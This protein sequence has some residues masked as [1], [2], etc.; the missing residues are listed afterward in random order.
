MGNVTCTSR[1]ADLSRILYETARK[2]CA[3]YGVPKI[4]FARVLGRR[5]H[6]LAGFGEETY[7]PPDRE[8][9][10]DGVWAFIEGGDRLTTEQQ[11]DL[12]RDLRRAVSSATSG[13]ES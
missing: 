10:G 7:L 13:R 8:Y 6:H 12:R 4:Y 3:V 2:A 9:L 1:T 5:L 11:A